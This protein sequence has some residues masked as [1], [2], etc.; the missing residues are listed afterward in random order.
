MALARP[1]LPQRSAR[2]SLTPSGGPS[3]EAFEGRN[4][5]ANAVDTERQQ[6]VQN[7]QKGRTVGS[8]S[9]LSET[10]DYKLTDVASVS[11]S[12]GSYVRSFRSVDAQES[13]SGLQHEV[14]HLVRRVLEC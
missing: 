8:V 3:L 10:P 5:I 12:A 9:R 11:G 2:L 14:V 1:G 6:V 13:L 7:I 4:R